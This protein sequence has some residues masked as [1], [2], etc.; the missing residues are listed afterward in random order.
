M[1]TA[2]VN[3]ITPGITVI[4]TASE[5]AVASGTPVTYTYAVSNS[6]DDPLVNVAVSDGVTCNPVSRVTVDANGLLDP[7]ES[8]TFLCSAVLTND[9]TNIATAKATDS[10]GN[11][12]DGNDTEYVEVVQAAIDLIKS[13]GPQ[14]DLR[15]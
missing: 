10:L 11:P 4:K 5:I 9:T 8:W 3:V 7:S 2:E 12:I 13:G 15:R 14:C 1:D 6:G